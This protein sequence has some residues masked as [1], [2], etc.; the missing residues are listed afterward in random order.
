MKPKPPEIEGVWCDQLGTV[1][2]MAVVEGW[3]VARRS[4]CIPFVEFWRD[5][6]KKH[7]QGTVWD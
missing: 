5:F 2:V 1:R 6:L 3:V 4:G 7:K